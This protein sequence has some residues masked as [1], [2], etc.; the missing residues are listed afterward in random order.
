MAA[1]NPSSDSTVESSGSSLSSYDLL[2]VVMPI[3]LL[4][5]G[6]LAGATGLPT[7]GGMGLGSLLSA[8]P[9]CY[10]LFVSPPA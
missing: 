7:V 9:L 8:V 3:P 2:L 4:A 5:G 1:T 10:A 6:V